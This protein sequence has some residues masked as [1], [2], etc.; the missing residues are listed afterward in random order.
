MTDQLLLNNKSALLRPPFPPISGEAACAD[1]NPFPEEGWAR[2]SAGWT[3]KMKQNE[4]K[5]HTRCWEHSTEWQY[6][7]VC[8]RSR[9]ARLTQSY[10]NGCFT[11]T[12][13]RS[14]W[15]YSFL[16]LLLNNK[17][18]GRTFFVLSYLLHNWGCDFTDLKLFTENR[19][20]CDSSMCG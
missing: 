15:K 11:F 14:H 12:I 2:D 7:G 17:H 20:M 3:K 19:Y 9:R 10:I 16:L 18:F 1:S 8:A 4:W 5:K 6:R 13:L